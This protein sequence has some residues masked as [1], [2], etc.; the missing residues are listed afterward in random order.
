MLLGCS[1]YYDVVGPRMTLQYLILGWSGDVILHF[2]T[3]FINKSSS[4]WVV[5]GY[6]F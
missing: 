3:T 5:S 4:A 2:K 1:G 6:S